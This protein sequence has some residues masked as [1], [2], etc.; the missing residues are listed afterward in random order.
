MS[1]SPMWVHC[2]IVTIAF[3]LAI[4]LICIFIQGATVLMMGTKEEDVVKET[5]VKPVF[6]EDMNETELATSVSFRFSLWPSKASIE[7]LSCIFFFFQLDLPA[8]LHNLGN[9]CYMNATIQCLKSVPELR[10]AL[11]SFKDS[12]FELHEVSLLV[13]AYACIEAIPIVTLWIRY[14][15]PNWRDVSI[16]RGI[17]AWLTAQYG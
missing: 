10:E 9:T 15:S 5:E 4:I 13:D 3:P 1:S 11:S 6:V 12:E 17:D 16:H 14:Q 7:A 2:H 8:G